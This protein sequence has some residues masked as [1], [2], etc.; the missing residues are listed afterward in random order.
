[1][2]NIHRGSCLCGQVKFEVTGDF[3]SFFLCH[4]QYCQKDTGSAH[5]ANLF[6]STAKLNWISGQDEIQTYTLPDTRHTKS[7]CLKCGSATPAPQTEGQHLKVPA[8]ILDTPLSQKPNAHI[9]MSSQAEWSKNLSTIKTFEK[10]P[11]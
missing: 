11:R 7:F 6:S 10:F 5:A 4:C 2:S 8:G 1:M 9:F 3:E